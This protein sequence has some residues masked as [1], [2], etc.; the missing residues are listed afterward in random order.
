ML[1]LYAVSALAPFLVADLGL[2]RAAV[3]GLATASFA[4]AA[5]L[6]LVAGHLTDLLGARRALLALAAAVTVA[7]LAASA[8][9]SYGWL[10]A[11]LA[12]AG[13]G[14]A[15]ANPATNV[16]LA[17]AVPT[18]RRGLAIGVKQ[19]GVQLTV[20]AAGLVLPP[21]TAAVGWRAALRWSALVPVVLLAAVWWLIP[22]TTRSASTAGSW[23]RWSAPSRWLAWLMGYSLLLG[24]GLAA[25]ATY[26]PLY[27]AQRLGLDTSAAGGVLAAFGLSGLAAR[28]WWARWADRLPEVS[29]AL[30][31][32]SAAAAVGVALVGLAGWWPGLV[33]AGAVGVG[34]TA[35]AAN[36]VSMLAVLRHGD[37]TGHASG[38]VSLGFFGGFV[39]GPNVFGPAADHAGYG[40]S[41]LAVGVVFAS[42]ALLARGVRTPSR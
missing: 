36:A 8:A 20:F 7:L 22:N 6:S 39:L 25:L 31:W 26:L 24:T 42:S 40:W 18:V 34:A 2:S 9:G 19:S 35:T 13:V 12:V 5:T 32:L 10:L 4:V 33:W 30:V 41:W 21:L 16:L 38:L 11:A 17:R 15:L 3:G 14:Q 28:V 27:A 29:G 23:W 37:S 1:S